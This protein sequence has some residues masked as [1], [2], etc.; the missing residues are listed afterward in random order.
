MCNGTITAIVDWEY[1]G[2]HP[3]YRGH[4]KAYSAFDNMPDWSTSFNLRRTGSMVV[5]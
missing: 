4:T 1:V 3:E 2:W 5:V